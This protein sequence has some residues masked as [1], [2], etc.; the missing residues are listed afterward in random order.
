MIIIMKPRATEEQIESLASSLKAQ[1]MDIQRNAGVDCV[2]LGVIGDVA[3]LDPHDFLIQPG[4]ERIMPVSEPFKKANRKFH[5][6]DSV[7]DCGGVPVGGRK[8]AI[9]AGPCSV[10]NYDQITDTAL[11]VRAAGANILRGGAYKPR[12]SPYAFQGLKLEGLSL[13]EQAKE[14]TG[15]PICTEIMSPQLVEEFDRRVDIIQVGARN[16][17]N[18]DL[19]TELG[20]TRKPILLKRGLSSTINE[21]LMSAEY[22]MAAG[23]PNVILCERGIRTFETY[24]RNTLD[25][26]AVQAVKRLSHLPVIV[27]PS[28]ATGLNWMVERMSIAAVAAGA[29]GLIIEVHNNPPRAL[30]D[31]AQSLTPDQFA[32]V[33]GKLHAIAPIVE[34]T[35]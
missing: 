10:E 5:P 30:C 35:L 23:N 13:L 14:L 6:N 27:D 21:W 29:D 4:V 1:G 33:M 15:M 32:Q 2:V 24:T 7:I 8:L 9:F 34:R 26:S 28:H 22:I 3:H 12:T 17:Q 19:L 25:L 31:G 11:K 20:K 16:M 18:F